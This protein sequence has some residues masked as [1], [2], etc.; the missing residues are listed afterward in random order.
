MEDPGNDPGA[1]ELDSVAEDGTIPLRLVNPS[2]KPVKVYGRTRPANFEEVDRNIATFEP[3]A[4]E[5]LSSDDHSLSY[6]QSK[7]RDYSHL[8]DLSDSTLSTDDKI[9][10]RDLFSKYRDVF[11]FSDAELRRTSLVQHVIDT[12]NATRV[13]QMLYRTSPEGK[14]EIDRQVSDMLEHRILQESV[15]A[16]SS[17][18]VLVKKMVL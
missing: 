12:G 10:F 18:V 16:W 1:S 13:K 15:S 17:P 9:K 11:A 5:K 2:F 6:Q 7:K 8:L 14:Q 4:S 3:S